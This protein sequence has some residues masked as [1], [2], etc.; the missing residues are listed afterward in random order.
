MKWLC[1]FI[2]LNAFMSFQ[3]W[4]DNNI[5]G[6]DLFHGSLNTDVF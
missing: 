4:F 5:V 2:N 6:D 1:D 3:F